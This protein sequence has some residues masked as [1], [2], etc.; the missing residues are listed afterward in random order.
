MRH[1][2]VSCAALVLLAGCG[3]SDAP[4]E[5]TFSAGAASV[6]AKPTQF[7]DLHL[8]NCQSDANAPV[9][10]AVPAGTS[11]KVAVPSE[12]SS[13]PWQVVFTYRSTNGSQTDGRSPVL[14]PNRHPDY[15]LQLPTATDALVT[16]Q[17]QQYGPPPQA[18]ANTGEI[19]FPI[20]ASWVLNAA[21]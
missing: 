12:I 13:A 17:V 6:V 10:L 7:C 4:P 11:L 15:T 21:G 18:N 19:E 1:L 16:A 14:A 8:Q 2:A 9:R 5:V 3:G 20:R